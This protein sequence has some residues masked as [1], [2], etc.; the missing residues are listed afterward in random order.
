M[1]I[2][3]GHV[4]RRLGLDQQM[5]FVSKVLLE[6]EELHLTAGDAELLVLQR[7]AIHLVGEYTNEDGPFAED[8]FFVIVSNTNE[9][10]ETGMSRI[11]DDLFQQLSSWLGAE[12]ASELEGETTFKSRAMWPSRFRGYAF[13]DFETRG[14]SMS[15][16]L[17]ENMR[18]QIP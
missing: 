12:I 14:L 5:V 15:I 7:S 16:S 11:S 2:R 1:A 8:H 3:E 10:Y 17:S 18:P 9:I 6:N 13:L 4:L